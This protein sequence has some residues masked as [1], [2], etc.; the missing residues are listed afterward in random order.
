MR[1]DAPGTPAGSGSDRVRRAGSPSSA[2]AG[3]VAVVALTAAA[4]TAQPAEP[5][6]ASPT[7]E[8]PSQPP[9]S[10]DAPEPAPAGVDQI[11]L[12]E[13]LDHVHGL[14]VAGDG[15]LRVG[16]HTGLAAVTTDGTVSRVGTSRDDLMGM[17]GVPGTDRL[18]SSGHPGAGSALPNP[19][20]LIASDDGGLSWSAVSLTGEV[21][22]HA[23]ATDGTVVVGYGGGSRVL[24]STDGG[25]TFTPGAAI[26]PAALAIT[27]GHVWATTADGPQHSTDNGQTF[28]V[29]EGAPLLVLIAAGADASLWGV[30]TEGVAWRSS[31]GTTWERRATVGPV[32]ALTVADHATAYA[33]TA[34]TLL[35][36]T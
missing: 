6:T 34:T 31:D 7:S 18:A 33:M 30:D 8:A 1:D 19:V 22:F 21:D 17:T 27:P 24:T 20:G 10:G 2:I 23:L 11:A 26:A 4:C 16:T 3:L 13:P 32:D 5:T 36:L 35:A 28:A 25:E 9:A 14:L 29:V 12:S 15:T